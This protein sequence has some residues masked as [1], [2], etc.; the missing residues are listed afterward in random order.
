[1]YQNANGNMIH[2]KKD[3]NTIFNIHKKNQVC[4]CV[5]VCVEWI[6]ISPSNSRIQKYNLKSF[7]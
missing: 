6:Q 4:V 7:L 3:M 5:C 1:M 2:L